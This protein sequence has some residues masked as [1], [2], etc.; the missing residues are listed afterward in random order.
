MN[1]VGMYNGVKMDNLH[2]RLNF[3][4]GKEKGIKHHSKKKRNEISKIVKFR[5]KISINFIA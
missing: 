5:I 4:P 1:L 2:V 3:N